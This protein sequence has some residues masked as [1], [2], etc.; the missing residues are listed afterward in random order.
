MDPAFLVVPAKVGLLT[1]LDAQT[2]S[3]DDLKLHGNIEHD[4]SLSRQDVFFGNNLHFNET[5]F[6]TLANANPGSDVYNVT[7]A[8]QVQHARLT[9]SI[10]KNPEV[11]NT[12]LQQ[13]IRSGESALYLSVMGDPLTGEAPKRFVQ[14]FFR[15]ERLPIEEGWKRSTVPIT[16]RT[17]GAL[18]SQISKASDWEPTGD[19]CAEIVLTPLFQ[20]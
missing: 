20:L 16:I 13:G 11:V 7:S 19:N 17:V 5:I 9:D 2:M 12:H 6:S 14:V 10:Q 8:G 4:A 15:E 18:F 3:L 1:S